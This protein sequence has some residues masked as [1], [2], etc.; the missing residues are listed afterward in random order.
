MAKKSSILTYSKGRQY[1]VKLR[2]K[3]RAK[4][5]IT[6]YLDQ[7]VGTTISK[8]G[9]KKTIRN[10]E[11]LKIDIKENPKNAEERNEYIERLRLAESIRSQ[12]EKILLTKGE[13][14]R[15]IH[16]KKINFLDYFQNYLDSYKNK[17]IRL[18][19]ACFSH[20]KDYVNADFLLPAEVTEDFVKGFKEHLEENLNG[21]TP[22]N[23][24][25]K[26]KALCKK[27]YRAKV[28]VE[29]F[30]E[31]LSI[32]RPDGLKK[33]ILSFEEI[34][35]LPGAHCGNNEVKM[36]FLFCLNT[37][38]RF[39]DVNALT[40]KNIDLKA[41]RLRKRQVKV[42]RSSKALVTIDLNE[43]AIAVLRLRTK[44][45]PDDQVFSLPT[46][47][48]SNKVLKNWVRRAGIEKHITWHCARHSF[49]TNLL[50]Y[51]ANIKTV[52][53]LLGHSGLRHTEK[54]THAVDELKKTAVNSLP[55]IEIAPLKKAE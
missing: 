38:L 30:A 21:D 44:G 9:K 45:Q 36:A 41:K 19:R 18:V 11:Y 1:K 3:V 10:L 39:V 8:D 46:L 51:N 17:D 31:H 54:Y 5:R 40:W 27:A 28:L 32:S 26:F 13:G 34:K 33:E 16:L 48:G 42:K 25:T 52:S 24:F 23:Y 53:D 2:G 20:F 4:G 49:A 37:G 15:A 43:T 50:Y 35:S 22:Y 12:R 47:E 55:P 7:Y 14:L 29:N 6:L